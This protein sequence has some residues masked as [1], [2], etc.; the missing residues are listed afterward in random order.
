VGALLLRSDRSLWSYSSGEVR[1]VDREL[2][3][4]WLWRARGHVRI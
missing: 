3:H 1:V 2:L 4:L